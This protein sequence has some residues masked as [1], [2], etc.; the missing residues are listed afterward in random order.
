MRRNSNRPRFAATRVADL[1]KLAR[2][3]DEKLVKHSQGHTADFGWRAPTEGPASSCP[4]HAAWR[5]DGRVK[6]I[7]LTAPIRDTSILPSGLPKRQASAPSPVASL[8]GPCVGRRKRCSDDQSLAYGATAIRNLLKLTHEGIKQFRLGFFALS[9][10]AVL[11]PTVSGLFPPQGRN[12][13]LESPAGS[14]DRSPHRK[15][16]RQPP[17]GTELPSGDRG[18]LAPNRYL[19]ACPVPS[20]VKRAPTLVLRA[21]HGGFPKAGAPWPVTQSGNWLSSAGNIPATKSIR[22]RVP[23]CAR[24]S[25]E[26][27]SVPPPSA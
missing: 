18:V 13:N 4:E 25:P 3:A 1:V 5:A 12:R 17:S 27:S 24:K 10:V 2:D 8:S 19:F 23:S 11:L 7:A 16:H 20:R 14:R 9:W 22:W 15:A 21:M 6:T 26:G